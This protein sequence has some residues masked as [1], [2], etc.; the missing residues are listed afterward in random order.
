MEKK[1]VSKSKTPHM[2]SLT[3]T[4]TIALHTFS[5]WSILHYPISSV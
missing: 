2:H 5:F 1:D 4:F 3:F